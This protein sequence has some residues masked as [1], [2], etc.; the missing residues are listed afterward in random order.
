MP[1]TNGSQKS[2]TKGQL[3]DNRKRRIN[4]GTLWHKSFP[5]KPCFLLALLDFLGRRSLCTTTLGG[6]GLYQG[7]IA[8]QFL[9]YRDATTVDGKGQTLATS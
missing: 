8:T 7:T 9:A 5:Q 3:Q 2:T 1:K 4:N 6:K